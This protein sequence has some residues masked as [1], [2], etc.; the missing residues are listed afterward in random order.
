MRP[1]RAVRRLQDRQQSLR[2]D[3]VPGVLR[4]ALDVEARST[5]AHDLR[6]RFADREADLHLAE[7]AS[8]DVDH[9]VV[10][11]WPSGW[12]ALHDVST[13]DVQDRGH[14]V[15][16]HVGADV[17]AIH[18]DVLVADGP[19]DPPIRVAALLIFTKC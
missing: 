7:N 3:V 9:V 18:L 4:D 12:R 17:V 10:T 5:R 19:R 8:L 2:D 16:E 1:P 11:A 14:H 6:C 13:N 15:L